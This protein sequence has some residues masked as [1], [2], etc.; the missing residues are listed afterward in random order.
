V[1]NFLLSNSF[2][3]NP[4]TLVWLDLRKQNV[5]FVWNTVNLTATYFNWYWDNEPNNYAEREY[6]VEMRPDGQW[7]DESCLKYNRK[8]NIKQKLTTTKK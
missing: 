6:C 8:Q 3:Q 1:F 5:T 7:N 2:L 4:K